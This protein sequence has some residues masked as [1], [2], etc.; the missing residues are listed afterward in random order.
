MGFF[1]GGHL[2]CVRRGTRWDL[3]AVRVS[4]RII[5]II[6]IYLHP[7]ATRPKSD[8]NKVERQEKVLHYVSL[9]RSAVMG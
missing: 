2:E 7:G 8:I 6:I 3:D 1:C 9:T 4:D 5:I